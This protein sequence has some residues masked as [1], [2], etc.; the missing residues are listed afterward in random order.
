MP[1]LCRFFGIVI[2]MYFNDHPP[3]HFHVKYQQHRAQ[4]AI[5]TL[6]ILEG[7]LPAK[8]LWLVRHWANQHNQ[9]LSNNWQNLQKTGEFA[10]I[11]P[12]KE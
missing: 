8:E 3:P 7:E 10:K 2:Y 4:I 11:A 9:E 6:E 1:E 12:L 5:D